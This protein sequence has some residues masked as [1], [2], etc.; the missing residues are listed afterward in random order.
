MQL[1]ASDRNLTVSSG[2]TLRVNVKFWDV[3]FAVFGYLPSRDASAGA[4]YIRFRDGDDPNTLSL[5]ATAGAIGGSPTYAFDLQGADENV[6]S[7]FDIRGAYAGVRIARASHCVIARNRIQH[8]RWRVYA[9][10]AIGQVGSSGTTI[11]GNDFSL[12]LYG[13]DHQGAYHSAN[14]TY[15]DGL[16]EYVYYGLKYLSGASN[17]ADVSIYMGFLG[18]GTTV[19]YNTFHDTAEGVFTYLCDEPVISNNVFVHMS[20]CGVVCSN[21]LQET[22]PGTPSGCTI[23]T[24]RFSDVAQGIRFDSIDRADPRMQDHARVFGNT[25]GNPGAKGDHIHA[26]YLFGGVSPASHSSSFYLDLHDNVFGMAF[27]DFDLSGYTAAR[28]GMPNASV[29]H[30]VFTGGALIYWGGTRAE[31]QKFKTT[32]TMWKLFDFNSMQDGGDQD[33][34]APAWRGPHNVVQTPSGAR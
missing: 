22:Y 33:G 32:S 5:R 28:G 21:A 10:G 2:G 29:V 16:K 6:V 11:T 26:H 14:P 9:Q 4:T 13:Y 12:G 27:A 30:N 34:V 3:F 8:G 1:L 24:N 18:S 17:T 20:D 7:D 31:L 23:A 19:Q 25:F 15:D